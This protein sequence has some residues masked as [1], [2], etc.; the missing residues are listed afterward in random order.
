MG[1]EATVGTMRRRVRELEMLEREGGKHGWAQ[2]E[3]RKG[4]NSW[5]GKMMADSTRKNICHTR[6]PDAHPCLD[7]QGL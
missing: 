3:V 5:Q 4:V 6:V 2:E 7:T 1:E